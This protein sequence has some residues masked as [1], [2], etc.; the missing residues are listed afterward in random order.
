MSR[1]LNDLQ[2]DFRAIV[3]EFLARLVEAG[4]NVIIID[5]LR[6]EAEHEANLKAGN[7][8]TSHSLHLDGLAIDVCHYAEWILRGHKKL[9]WDYNDPIWGQ[10]G[11]IGEKVGL[12]WGVWLKRTKNVPVWLRRG[13]FVNIDLGHLEMPSSQKIPGDIDA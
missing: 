11:A 1:A 6:T 8:W 4:I 13:E 3:F 9:D 7:S 5:T 12:K 2:L 10:I